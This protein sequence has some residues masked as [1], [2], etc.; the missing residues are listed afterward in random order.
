MWRWST[1]GGTAN[2]D[3]LPSLMADLVRR[4]R[5]RYRHARQ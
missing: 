5:G 4:S 2:T 1:T 3:R